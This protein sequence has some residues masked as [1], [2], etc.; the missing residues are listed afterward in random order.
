MSGRLY[1]DGWY[2]NT[3]KSIAA[4]VTQGGTV[5]A[6]LQGA[7]P[8]TG[9]G[10]HATDQLTIE[11]D[12]F[13]MAIGPYSD[14]P[15][16]WVRAQNIAQPLYVG[17]NCPFIGAREGS[18][19]AAPGRDKF[20]G[21]LYLKAPIY[22]RPYYMFSQAQTVDI[23]YY[24][25]PPEGAIPLLRAPLR[26]EEISAAT[27][28]AYYC[29][30]GRRKVRISAAVQSL[31]NAVG[32]SMNVVQG[33]TTLLQ[34]TTNQIQYGAGYLSTAH[35]MVLA[36]G[37]NAVGVWEFDTIGFGTSGV[38]TFVLNANVATSVYYLVEAWD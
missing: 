22:I 6:V 4:N 20:A 28:S 14:A 37:G 1:S 8:T 2:W 13:A 23:Y 34:G 18:F 10:L 38:D 31:P 35:D 17:V 29:V 24:S 19:T 26:S 25:S 5:A 33:R 12:C 36:G 11:D 16:Y 15:G 27:A 30:A 21:P 3:P 9:F 32:I 7:S